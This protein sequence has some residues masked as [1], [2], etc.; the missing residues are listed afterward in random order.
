[1]S[2]RSVGLFAGALAAILPVAELYGQAPEWPIVVE[3]GT[4]FLM[5][6]RVEAPFTFTFDA[7]TLRVN[8]IPVRPLRRPGRREILVTRE[9]RERCGLLTRCFEVCEDLLEGGFSGIAIRDTLCRI[10]EASPM[11]EEV[12]VHGTTGCALRWR[13]GPVWKEYVTLPSGKTPVPI[14]WPRACLE[15]A[16]SYRRYLSRGWVLVIGAHGETYL[17]PGKQTALEREI[18]LLRRVGDPENE[19]IRILPPDLAVEFLEEHE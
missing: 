11:V 6:R 14:P 1:M 5:G 9:T 8:G 15:S 13:G 19:G 12:E 2:K 16:V 10:L 7:D 3:S 4:L 18:G 17:P